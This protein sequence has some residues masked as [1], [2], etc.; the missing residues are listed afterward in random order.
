MAML[1]WMRARYHCW[2]RLRLRSLQVQ[3]N[4]VCRLATGYPYDALY[5]HGDAGQTSPGDTGGEG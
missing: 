5:R 4:V 2:L 3:R 1:R